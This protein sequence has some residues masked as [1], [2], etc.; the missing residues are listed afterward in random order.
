MRAAFVRALVEAAER[1]DRVVLLTG[2][3]GFTVIEPFADRFPDRFFN[4][5]VA[6]QNM[7]GVATGLAE[8]GFVP[9]AYSIATF[10]AIRPYE[11]IRNG[12]VLHELPVRIVGVGGGLEYGTNG[13]T[14]YALEDLALMRAQ[15]GLTVIAPADHRQA[16]TALHATADIGGPVYFRLGK[17]E[18]TVLPGLDGRFGVGR[19]HMLGEPAD[20]VVVAV[21]SIAREAVG[22]VEELRS[23]GIDATLV[24]V[25]CV[26]PPP[27]EDLVRAIE[28]AQLVVT[29]ESHYR[30][31]GIGSLVSEVVADYGLAT[32]VLRC[33]IDCVPRVTGSERYLNELYGISGGTVAAVVR[34]ALATHVNGRR[35][36][37]RR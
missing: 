20:I 7:I 12:P 32:R 29:V 6:E 18:S 14:H 5:G 34:D 36:A 17:D 10:A 31:G 11:F 27:T 2:D 30:T 1:D 21:G 25:S 23:S 9:F 26:S 3:L 15:P 24:V 33:G 4:V 35:R 13:V 22:T 28:P 19:A 16:R 37:G 8:A